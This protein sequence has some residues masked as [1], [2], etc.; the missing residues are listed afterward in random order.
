MSKA[1]VY[2][3]LAEDLSLTAYLSLDENIFGSSGESLHISS[4][5]LRRAV[6]PALQSPS[7]NY[8]NPHHNTFNTTSHHGPSS[9]SQSTPHMPP[10]PFTYFTPLLPP[11]TPFY[12]PGASPYPPQYSSPVPSP[13]FYS[14]QVPIYPSQFYSPQSNFP[15]RKPSSMQNSYIPKQSSPSNN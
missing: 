2:K 3:Q 4:P 13:Q 7:R 5:L 8:T 12:P 6:M 10:Q 1:S 9:L 14:P 11:H 15:I